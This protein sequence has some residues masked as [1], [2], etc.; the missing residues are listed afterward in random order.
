MISAGKEKVKLRYRSHLGEGDF[1]EAL[2]NSVTKDRYLAYT[3]KEA[4]PVQIF[5]DKTAEDRS[6]RVARL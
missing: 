3:I 1:A 2:R 5:P 6:C 4:A